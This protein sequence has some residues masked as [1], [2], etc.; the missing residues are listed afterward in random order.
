MPDLHAY[1]DARLLALRQVRESV[2][3]SEQADARIDELIRLK[4]WLEEQGEEE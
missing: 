2:L 3:W 1:I 4:D